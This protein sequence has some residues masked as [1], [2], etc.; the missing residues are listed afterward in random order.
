MFQNYGVDPEDHRREAK[1][2]A[3]LRGFSQIEPLL[4]I[5]AY[6]DDVKR[7]EIKQFFE[8]NLKPVN[9]GLILTDTL[10]GFKRNNL[11]KCNK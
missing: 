9:P 6:A 2:I 11:L 4:C 8:H 7:Q 3:M 5:G 1:E 10:A